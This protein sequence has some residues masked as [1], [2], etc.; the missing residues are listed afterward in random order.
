MFLQLLAGKGNLVNL[1]IIAQYFFSLIYANYRYLSLLG[2]IW[3][4]GMENKRIKET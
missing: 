4:S 2:S 3:N 1:L